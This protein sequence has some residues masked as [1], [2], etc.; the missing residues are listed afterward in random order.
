MPG[1]DP[2]KIRTEDELRDL[3]GAP[4][5]IVEAKVSDA[6]DSFGIDYLAHSPFLSEP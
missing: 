3:I 4:N 5:A 2:H 6:L 1:D